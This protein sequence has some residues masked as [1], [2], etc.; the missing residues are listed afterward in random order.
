M[1]FLRYQQLKASRQ[2]KFIY[3]LGFVFL[4]TS[5]FY[6]FVVFLVPMKLL[7]SCFLDLLL[8][9]IVMEIYSDLCLKIN[10]PA[11]KNFM[12]LFSLNR[13]NLTPRQS[14]HHPPRSQPVA[15]V[16]QWPRGH[17]L[18]LYPQRGRGQ[19]HPSVRYPQGEQSPCQREP[20]NRNWLHR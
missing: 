8:I 7:S 11:E 4:K 13:P 15:A 14:L 16:P 12:S 5:I 18:V 2:W 10:N 3:F 20:T 1:S 6:W 17:P 19:P 9:V